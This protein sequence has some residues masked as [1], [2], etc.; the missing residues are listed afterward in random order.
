MTSFLSWLDTDSHQRDQAMA[1]LDAFRD[2]TTVDELGVGSIRDAITHQLFPGS[3]VLHTRA[4]YLLFIPWLVADAMAAKDADAAVAELRRGEVR[5]IDVLAESDDRQGL[6]G[7]QARADLRRMPSAMYWAALRSYGI[8]TSRAS[9]AG[10]LRDGVAFTVETRRAPREADGEHGPTLLRPGLDPHALLLRPRDWPQ[11]ASFALT[12]AEADYL[13]GR[14]MTSHPESLYAWFLRE[15]VDVETAERFVWE[16]PRAGDFPAAMARWVEH[17][18]AFS[19]LNR[20]AALLYNLQLAEAS[21]DAERTERYRADLLEWRATVDGPDGLRNW[22]PDIFWQLLA[23]TGARI[24]RPTCTFVDR[25][26][27]LVASGSGI[28]DDVA[29]RELIAHRERSLKGPRAR[30]VNP[31][32]LNAWSGASALGQLQYNWPIVRRIIADI[33][34]GARVETVV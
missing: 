25:W 7:G 26:H 21:E 23:G 30:L 4:R 9:I 12:P 31:S 13:R 16:H 32:A 17:G 28:V 14:I 29:A 20:G 6:I 1:V 5:L 3:S 24:S 22:S 10:L 27:G 18:R 11:E 8:S 34:T 2:R 19:V 33:H 15:E